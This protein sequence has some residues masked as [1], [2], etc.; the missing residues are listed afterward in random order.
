M[1]RKRRPT[2]VL[3]F[4]L[5]V[6]PYVVAL[7]SCGTNKDSGDASVDASSSSDSAAD[8]LSDVL[9]DASA[10]TALDVVTCT[11]A[12]GA[13][14][15]NLCAQSATC[16]PPSGEGG[17][18][19]D[20]QL[21]PCGADFF[22]YCSPAGGDGLCGSPSPPNCCLYP[23]ATVTPGACGSISAPSGTSAVC[24]NACDTDGGSGLYP[25]IGHQLCTE[26]G[27]CEAG[28]GGTCVPKYIEGFAFL[29]GAVIGV[30][31]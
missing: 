21:L 15:L 31:E 1:A 28:V 23:S 25:G 10:D 6:S 2:S 24:G 11:A 17:L 9:G 5:V 19:C 27:Q 14:G 30:C 22:Y 13:S 8:T 16:Y 12:L 26:N 4:A 3:A 18:L 7:S 29:D 20:S